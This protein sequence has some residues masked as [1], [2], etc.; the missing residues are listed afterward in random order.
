MLNTPW[1][2]DPLYKASVG[3]ITT[4]QSVLGCMFIM[5]SPKLPNTFPRPAASN[6]RPLLGQAIRAP[7]PFP[8]QGVSDVA[9]VACDIYGTDTCI[10]LTLG[11][12]M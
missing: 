1:K 8:E 3:L 12:L 11:D 6:L 9:A 10:R 7:P 5:M 2:V 4:S